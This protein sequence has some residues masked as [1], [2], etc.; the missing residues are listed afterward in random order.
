MLHNKRGKIAIVAVMIFSML[1]AYGAVPNVRAASFESAKA[2][3]GDS[4]PSQVATTTIIVDIG[5]SLTNGQ[6][7]EIDLG[8]DGAT[9][10]GAGDL[11]GFAAICPTGLTAST[12]N[13]VA[14]EMVHCMAGGGGF[15]EATYATTTIGQ[16][17]IPAYSA[18]GHKI[19]ITTRDTDGTEIETSDVIVYPMAAVE[20]SAT[21]DASLT[22][23]ISGTTGTIN[24][25][26][27]TVTATPTT[28]PFSNLT[29]GTPAIGAQQLSVTTNAAS[30]Y[31]V[32]V[33]QD[34]ELTSGAGA[35]INNFNNAPNGQGSSTEG[36]AWAA[37]AGT[38]NIDRT[39]G[40]FGLTSDDD[41]LDGSLFADEGDNDPF[42][43]NEWAGMNGTNPIQVMY[44]TGPADGS[45]AGVGQA[46]VAYAVQIDALQ[47]AGDYTANLT[48]VCTPTY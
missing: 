37:P 15:D 33:Q 17:T 4:T 27:T 3:L 12:T 7:L 5:T 30:G 25:T 38:L 16:I 41:S 1:M 45:T 42:D 31:S 11:T 47:E 35:T 22:F 9:P 36:V 14:M 26:S 32:T 21:V 23:A 43:S 44:H 2:I 28:I 39:Y 29:V 46:N 8:P 48:Y 19:T 10:Y 13:T 24:G 6:Y 18:S 34:G 40:H 20:V